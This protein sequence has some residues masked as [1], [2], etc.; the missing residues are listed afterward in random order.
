MADDK[1][2]VD[3]ITSTAAETKRAADYTRACHFEVH[4]HGIEEAIAHETSN[5][6]ESTALADRK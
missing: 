2:A 6:G 3:V 5:G 4:A 1:Q